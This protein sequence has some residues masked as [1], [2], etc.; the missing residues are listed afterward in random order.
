LLAL[1]DFSDSSG[2]VIH[3]CSG[4]ASPLE[5][6]IENPRA[7]SRTSGSLELRGKAAIRSDKPARKVIAAVWQSGEITIEA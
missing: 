7:V 6:R 1:Y 2:D 4:L 5:L 3:N